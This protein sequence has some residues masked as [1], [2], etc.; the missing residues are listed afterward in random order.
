MRAKGGTGRT[1]LLVTQDALS[2]GTIEIS[3]R[4]SEGYLRTDR[5]SRASRP[6]E[7]PS[8]ASPAQVKD[9]ARFRP[10]LKLLISSATLDAEKFS[11]YF[12]YA[13]IFRIPGR[14]YPVDILYTKA[15]EVGARGSACSGTPAKQHI[16]PPPP[17]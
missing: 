9:I 1:C 16:W 2:Q 4:A 17:D 8:H 11:E 14:R 10:D 5:N 7:A 15:P 3:V 13:P 6:E 12:D